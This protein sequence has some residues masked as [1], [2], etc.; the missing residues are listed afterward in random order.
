MSPINLNEVSTPTAFG[1]IV[2]T[3]QTDRQT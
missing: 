1:Q 2:R 3:G